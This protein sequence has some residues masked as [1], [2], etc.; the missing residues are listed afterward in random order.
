MSSSET[1]PSADEDYSVGSDSGG[2]RRGTRRRRGGGRDDD[3]VRPLGTKEHGDL[4]RILE[5]TVT[6]QGRIYY[7][8]VWSDGVQTQV[9]IIC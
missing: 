2:E 5:R 9:G 1:D 6:R 4:V 3:G 8:V 7:T